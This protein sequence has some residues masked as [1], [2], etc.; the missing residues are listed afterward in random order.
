MDHRRTK[1]LKPNRLDYDS[2]RVLFGF[3]YRTDAD[4][5]RFCYDRMITGNRKRGISRQSVSK[6]LDARDARAKKQLEKAKRKETSN[7]NG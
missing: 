5:I 3:R 1:P 2:V 7:A 6:Y 4:F